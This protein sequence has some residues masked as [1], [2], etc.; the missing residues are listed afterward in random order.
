M[1]ALLG[2]PGA[3]RFCVN[4]NPIKR[5]EREYI[6]IYTYTVYVYIYTVNLY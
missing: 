4:T 3:E 5:K 1:D 2:A 6:Y